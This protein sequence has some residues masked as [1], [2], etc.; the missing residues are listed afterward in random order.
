[1]QAL[2]TLGVKDWAL[3]GQPDGAF[4]ATAELK[5]Q[6]LSLVQEYQPKWVF[7]P[8][9]LDYHRDHLRITAFLEPLCRIV[10]SVT[11]LV[12]YEIWAPV[13]ATHVVDITNQL[14]TKHAALNKHRTALAYGD[15]QAACDGLN[16]YRGLYLG[17]D[18]FA[19]AFWVNAVDDPHPFH[20]LQGFSAQLVT[21]LG[22]DGAAV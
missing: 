11:H 10:P 5:L 14:P 13:P 2:Q 16:R 4:S 1:V 20:T 19:E 8:S 17:R 21:N 6:V 15:Y 7:M 9:P 3:L 12:F 18:R 22:Q